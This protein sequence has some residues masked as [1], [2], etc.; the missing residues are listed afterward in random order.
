MDHLP[1][2]VANLKKRLVS[3]SRDK[4]KGPVSLEFSD[5][6]TAR[7][8]VL[9]GCDGIK[10]VVR[11]RMLQDKASRGD[12][13]MLNHIEPFWSGIVVYRAL[14]PAERLP[15]RNGKLHPVMEDA[16]MVCFVVRVLLLR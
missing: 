12:T 11:R 10:S 6:T 13:K 16:M 9:L 15:K 5:G 1:Q 2:G 4:P 3:Y 14:V 7:C 8:D